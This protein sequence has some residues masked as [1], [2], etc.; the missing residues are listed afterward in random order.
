MMSC[1]VDFSSDRIAAWPMDARVKPGHD[2]E[3]V[4]QALSQSPLIPAKAGIQMNLSILIFGAG[5]PP[6]R[7]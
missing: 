5:C 6:A 7:A 1:R 2:A 4:A 3:C